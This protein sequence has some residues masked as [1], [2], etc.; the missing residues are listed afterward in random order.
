MTNRGVEYD[1][2]V[3][4][5]CKINLKFLAKSK[6]KKKKLTLR[7]LIEELRPEIDQALAADH[8]MDAVVIV[9]V[10]AGVMIKTR[11]LRQYLRLRLLID[12][13]ENGTQP[14][15]QGEVEIPDEAA[16]KKEVV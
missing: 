6:P 10:E 7:D 1:S 8:T 3:A 5:E 4:K 9:L 12:N 11:T 15:V 13:V 14:D 2:E 16:T